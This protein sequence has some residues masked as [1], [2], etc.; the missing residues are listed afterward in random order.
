LS[1]PHSPSCFFSLF[2]HASASASPHSRQRAS[3]HV[4]P[5]RIRPTPVLTPTRAVAIVRP[6]GRFIACAHHRF[7]RRRTSRLPSR[8]SPYSSSPMV[9]T[10]S[11]LTLIDVG[12]GR[13][14]LALSLSPCVPP[15]RIRWHLPRFGYLGDEES[16]SEILY[17]QGP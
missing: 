17:N 13:V 14:G 4:P 7:R 16:R 9:A 1:P 6:R 2:P 5:P 12:T 10:T 11:R 8:P 3:E 15:R